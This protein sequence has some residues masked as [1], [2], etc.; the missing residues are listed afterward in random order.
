MGYQKFRTINQSPPYGAVFLILCRGPTFR[1]C[2]GTATNRWTMRRR[3]FRKFSVERYRSINDSYVLNVK[4]SE[5][6]NYHDMPVSTVRNIIR[7]MSTSR[8]KMKQGRPAKLNATILVTLDRFL[9]VNRLLPLDILATNFS[10]AINVNISKSTLCGYMKR[11]GFQ[12]RA[13]AA[14]QF[15]SEKNLMRRTLW[16]LMHFDKNLLQWSRV[17]FTDE[18]T[19]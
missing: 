18:S 12:S 3:G 4:P 14:N 8:T 10:A 1:V 6:G 16:G 2:A 5:I 11:I 17:L 19:F 13:V 7:Q 15:I 9:E